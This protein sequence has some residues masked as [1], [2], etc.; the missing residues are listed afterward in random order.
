MKK[1]SFKQF[2]IIQEN[3]GMK[4]T[5]DAVIFG[6]W[7]DVGKSKKILDI[8]TGTGILS[9]MLA[10]RTEKS[11]ITAIE[12]DKIA[13]NEAKINVKNCKWSKNIEVVEIDFLEFAKKTNS[14]YDLI[15]CNP[16]YYQ[17]HLMSINEKEQKAKHSTNLSY[18]SLISNAS[19]L[20]EYSGEFALIAPFFAY[21]KINYLCNKNMLFCKKKCIVRAETKKTPTRVL[22]QYTFTPCKT[23]EYEL[24]IKNDIHYTKDFLHLTSD[25]YIFA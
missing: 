19:K 12:I 17:E 3:A 21:Q 8:G 11:D 4:L 6:S 13:V 18:E 2:D 22:M 5:T 24:V 7:V 10:Q 14:K 16:P 20:L 25:F 9:I 15:I 1:F 23:N